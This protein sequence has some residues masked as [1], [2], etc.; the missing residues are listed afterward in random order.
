MPAFHAKAG[1]PVTVWTGF[2]TVH[3]GQAEC[4][5]EISMLAV[6]AIDRIIH[7]AI[8]IEIE[9]ETHRSLNFTQGS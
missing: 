8:I 4:G 3:G 1:A 7:H 5:L 9:E 2:G 6:A